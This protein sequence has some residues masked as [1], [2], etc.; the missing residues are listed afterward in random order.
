[1]GY[2]TKGSKAS[3]IAGSTFGGLLSLS[4]FLISQKQ[5]IGSIVGTIVGSMLSYV[6]GMKFLASKK[7]MPAGLIASLGVATT[8]YNAMEAFG[9]GQKVNVESSMTDETPK[10]DPVEE[11]TSTEE[12]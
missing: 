11:P 12:E 3:L 8:V 10:D 6:M 1:M 7:F 2:V 4:A 9:G 5:K